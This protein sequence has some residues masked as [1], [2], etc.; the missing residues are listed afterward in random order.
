[1]SHPNFVPREN[2]LPRSTSIVTQQQEPP[3]HSFALGRLGNTQHNTFSTT[4]T[5]QKKNHAPTSCHHHH[6]GP[7]QHQ[8]NDNHHL[9]GA[10]G[11]AP[12]ATRR[13]HFDVNECRRLDLGQGGAQQHKQH[14][15]QNTTIAT[16]SRRS[17]PVHVVVRDGRRSQRYGLAVHF[18]LGLGMSHVART[19]LSAGNE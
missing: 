13:R 11:M 19:V 18:L 1:M 10:S 4:H 17:S 12:M 15:N 2:D 8:W 16:S 14:C 3:P 5:I 6:N 7:S 9:L